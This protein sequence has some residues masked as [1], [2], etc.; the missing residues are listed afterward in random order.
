MTI[1]DGALARLTAYS[2]PGNVREL[3]NLIERMVILVSDDA[4]GEDDVK[5]CLGGA[6]ADL[7]VTGLYRAG[8]PLKV[9]LED[10]ERSI[11]EEALAHHGG[12]MTAVARALAIERSNAYQK[13]KRLGVKYKDDD[14]GEG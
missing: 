3:K 4:I 1:S 5:T 13:C 8:V 14:E 2:F 11:L 10:A 12:K 6:G 7:A 9:L